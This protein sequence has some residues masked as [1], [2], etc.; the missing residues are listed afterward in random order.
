LHATYIKPNIVT[1]I[2]ERRLEWARHLLRIPED[3][4]KYFWKKY[5]EKDKLES[6][7]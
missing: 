5:S 1:T 6:E 3:K 2:K 7:N 4:T